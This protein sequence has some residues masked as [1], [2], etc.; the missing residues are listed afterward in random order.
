MPLNT[1]QIPLGYQAPDFELLD[2]VLGAKFKLRQLQS[3]KAT[4]VMFICNH[5]PYVKHVF[6][7]V[8]SCVGVKSPVMAA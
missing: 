1:K 7:L 3:D 2:V 4:V 8:I 6:D 5:C